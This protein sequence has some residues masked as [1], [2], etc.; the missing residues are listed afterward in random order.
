METYAK[1]RPE[2]AYQYFDDAGTLNFEFH[3][4]YCRSKGLHVDGDDAIVVPKM[5]VRD[6]PHSKPI[7]IFGQDESV[8]SQFLFLPKSWVGPIK[9]R[10]TFQNQMAR[11]V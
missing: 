10:G 2:V 5:S 11:G 9:E 8:F 3:V 1:L 4:D 7:E 6:P